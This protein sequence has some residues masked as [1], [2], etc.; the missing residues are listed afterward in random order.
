MFYRR[1]D[2]GSKSQKARQQRRRR[3][4]VIFQFNLEKRLLDMMQEPSWIDVKKYKTNP[5]R[6]KINANEEQAIRDDLE[7]LKIMPKE[8]SKKLSDLKLRSI[9]TANDKVRIHFTI[10][11]YRSRVVVGEIEFRDKLYRNIVESFELTDNGFLFYD[12]GVIDL[13]ELELLI[14]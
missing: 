11:D 3:W 9:R 12:G 10:D 5:N 1:L 14:D 4:E 13:N 7:N 6:L 2:E 8:K